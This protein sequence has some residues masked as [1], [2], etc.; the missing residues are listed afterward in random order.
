MH[1]A[2]NRV[3]YSLCMRYVFLL[4]YFQTTF[5]CIDGMFSSEER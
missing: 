5:A 4:S 3:A 2:Q 1:F